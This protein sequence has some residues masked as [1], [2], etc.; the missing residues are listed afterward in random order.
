M[1]KAIKIKG[2]DDLETFRF[3]LVE[4]RKKINIILLCVEV[5]AA[6]PRRVKN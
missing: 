5:R 3:Q 4:Q 2:R 6:G 1:S